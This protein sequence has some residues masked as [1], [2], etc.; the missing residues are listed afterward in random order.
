M[1]R[2]LPLLVFIIFL[3]AIIAHIYVIFV[4]LNEQESTHLP[5]HHE[6]IICGEQ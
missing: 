4:M 1:N 6:S 3:F 2:A 5:D